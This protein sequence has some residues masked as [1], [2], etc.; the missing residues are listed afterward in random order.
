MEVFTKMP[1]LR[2]R[3]TRFLKIMEL[4]WYV[5]G[6]GTHPPGQKKCMALQVPNYTVN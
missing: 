4:T 5:L 3:L 1:V 2:F 6:Y